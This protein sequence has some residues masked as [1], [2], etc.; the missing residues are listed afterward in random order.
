MHCADCVETGISA[1]NRIPVLRD[2]LPLDFIGAGPDYLT[3]Q[4]M[5]RGIEVPVEIFIDRHLFDVSAHRCTI[6]ASHSQVSLRRHISCE[7]YIHCFEPCETIVPRSKEE[8]RFQNNSGI[9]ACR[10]LPSPKCCLYCNSV[11]KDRDIRHQT[12]GL[13]CRLNPLHRLVQG[14]DLPPSMQESS[15]CSHYTRTPPVTDRSRKNA[16]FQSPFRFG[17]E[18]YTDACDSFV[19]PGRS[20]LT[21]ATI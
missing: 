21:N 1:A 11:P 5:G 6:A 4:S 17:R 20:L 15:Q 12:R 9:L 16:S 10:S 8:I 7:V 13:C 19:K 18:S 14:L 3:A 2:F